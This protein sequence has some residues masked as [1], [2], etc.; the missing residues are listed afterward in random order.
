MRANRESRASQA[1]GLRP[2]R[3]SLEEEA[4][5]LPLPAG[6]SALSSV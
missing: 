1:A 2:S 3:I 4:A 6:P 5:P